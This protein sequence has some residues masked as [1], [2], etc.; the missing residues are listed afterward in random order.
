MKM[1]LLKAYNGILANAK[2]RYVLPE[3]PVNF[4]KKERT[5]H[6]NGMTTRGGIKGLLKGQKHFVLHMVFLLVA[7]FIH[8]S[9]WFA[10]SLNLIR[11]SLPHI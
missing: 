5:T 8:R 9:I 11:R 6:W 7:S 2:E 10:V 3:L 4:A 1:S